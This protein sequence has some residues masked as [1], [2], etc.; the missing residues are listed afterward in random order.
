V[1]VQHFLED[2]AEKYRHKVALICEN[3]RHTYGQLNQRCDSLAA[4][5]IAAGV[6]PGDRVAICL[7]NSPELVISV[8]ATLKAGAVFLL[9]NPTTKT[10][11]LTHIL[12][13]SR[14]TALVLPERKLGEIQECWE[15]TPHLQIVC[16]RGDAGEAPT[17]AGK[18]FFSMDTIADED[19][20][21]AALPGSSRIDLDLAA[22]LYTS[23][24]TGHPKGV[25][26][27]HK[28]I[29]SAA[30]SVTT[31]LE[32][33]SNDI[34]LDV[35]PLFFGYGL[36]QVLMTFSCGGTVVLERSFAFPHAVLEKMSR[37]AVTGLAIVPTIASILLQMDLSK[38]DLSALRYIT[39]AGAAL[40]VEHVRQLR[41]RLPHVKLFLMHG[42]TE[43]IR[44]CYLPPSEVDRRPGSVG[45]AMPNCELYLVDEA[46]RRVPPGEAGELVV[47]G[48]N[49]MLGYW[50]LPEETAEVLCPG[51]LPGEKV[52]YSGDLFK[53]DAEGYLYFLSRMDDLIKVGG[54]RVGPKE[55]EDVLCCIPGVAQAAAVGV[56][57][58]LLGTVIK[59]VLRLAPGA[60]LTVREVK[61]Y[62]AN[63]LDDMLVPK[64]VEFRDV[65]PTT[66][67]GKV[68]REE[69]RTAL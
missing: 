36:Y 7:E 69:L 29:C 23:G 21:G 8:F 16:V 33:K 13:N 47:R 28:N 27:T 4:A 11:K 67:T 25:M 34:I 26:L 15:Q 41:E 38:Y 5:L 60:S 45:K 65:L 57:D 59:A 62:C 3:Q 19:T 44:T 61:A 58:P 40:P 39:N 42:L 43:C 9:V 64:F 14:A 24:S 17:A 54:Q 51:P 46:G 6:R 35:L 1:L 37:E 30:K 32:N 52:L 53:T 10:Q 2:S 20:G 12:N 50:E 56:P 63:H 49:V 18:H 66:E 55:I 68:R 22:L 31:Y 48:S